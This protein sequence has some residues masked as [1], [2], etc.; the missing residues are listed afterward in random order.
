MNL[1]FLF[2]MKISNITQREQ[3]SLMSPHVYITNFYSY[4]LSTVQGLFLSSS[5]FHPHLKQINLYAYI[6]FWL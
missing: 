4:P 2:L 6:S 5:I 1:S 3:K